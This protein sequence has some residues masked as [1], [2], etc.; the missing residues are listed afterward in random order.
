MFSASFIDS[1]SGDGLLAFDAV[2]REFAAF[3]GLHK[4]DW[5]E[6][7]SDYELALAL[8]TALSEKHPNIAQT[9]SAVLTGHAA[10][11]I[12]AVRIAFSNTANFVADR[13]RQRTANELLESNR[14]RFKQMLAGAVLYDFSDDDYKRV[15][16]LI[17]ELREIISQSTEFAEKHQYRLLRRLERLQ[18]ELHKEMSDL[19]RFVGFFFD[20]APRLGQLGDDV[21]PLVKRLNELSQIIVRLI[22]VT[23]KLPAPK[24]AKLLGMNPAADESDTPAAEKISG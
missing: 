16:I 10:S 1:L 14:E 17:N 8:L 2:C 9:A 13:L 12:K 20:I 11:N 18:S 24:L 3:D 5:S 21:E 6:H 22:S 15:Q 4:E 19:D 7:T 23:D